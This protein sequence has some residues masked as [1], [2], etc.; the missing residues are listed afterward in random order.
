MGY[1]YYNEWKYTY[2]QRV[3]R[4]RDIDDCPLCEYVYDPIHA[5]VYNYEVMDSEVVGGCTTYYLNLTSQVWMDG[6]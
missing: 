6:K 2:F 4:R 3:K 5:D 1:Y